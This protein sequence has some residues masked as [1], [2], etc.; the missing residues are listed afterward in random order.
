[1]Q[2]QITEPVQDMNAEDLPD[3][4]PQQQEFV[5]GLLRGLSATE[6]YKVAYGCE[7]WSRAAIQVKASKLRHKAMIGVWLRAAKIGALEHNVLTLAQH[8]AELDAIAEEAKAA[9]NFGAAVNALVNKGKAA[10]LY[11]ERHMDMT[12][13]AVNTEAI[14]EALDPTKGEI[15][16]RV[17]ASL[18]VRPKGATVQ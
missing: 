2:N 18:P 13:R 11:V 5:V 7:G 15:Y 16:N 6:A 4:T 14:A 1:M 17:L 10:G 8:V 12:P 3:L 9:G